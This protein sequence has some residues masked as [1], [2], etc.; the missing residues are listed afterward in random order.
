M[1][2]ML[3]SLH[4]FGRW[5]TL[6]GLLVL[7]L[8][9]C[10]ALAAPPTPTPTP[11][12]TSIPSATPTPTA[13]PTPAPT[14]TPTPPC[15]AAQLA[16]PGPGQA[17]VPP[18]ENLTVTWAVRNTGSCTWQPPFHLHALADSELPD[19]AVLTKQRV[20]PGETVDLQAQIQAPTSPGTYTGH[21]QIVWG[22]DKTLPPALHY[23]VRVP[24]PTPTP[25]PTPGPPVLRKGT[26]NLRAGHTANFDNGAPDIIYKNAGPGDFQIMHNTP[27]VNF[28]RFYFWPPDFADCYHAHYVHQDNAILFTNPYQ[29]VGSTYCFITDQRRLGIMHID[30]A[31]VDG[32]GTPHLIITYVTWNAFLP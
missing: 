32:N 9:A 26:I 21:W 7:V 29:P 23:T 30:G 31:Y 6:S 25:T 14:P 15:L 4:R 3:R 27:V 28:H 17:Q 12:P 20:A 5:G 16:T 1:T 8:A 24:S 18:G 13:T 11:T 22:A 10:S 19:A 2:T